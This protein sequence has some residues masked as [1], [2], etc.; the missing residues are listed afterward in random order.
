MVAVGVALT[1][2]AWAQPEIDLQAER[3]DRKVRINWSNSPEIADSL[4]GG[5]QVWRST[6]PDPDTFVLLR[7]FQRRYP[8]T[9]TYGSPVPGGRRF[10]DD[11]DSVVA[12][13]KVQINE[14]GDSAVTREYVG[15]RPFNGFPYF[16][17]TT[18]LSE[19][20]SQ[21]NDTLW[22]DQPQPTIEQVPGQERYFFLQN[23]DTLDV[24][25]IR[26]RRIDPRT[27]R[28]DTTRFFF[29]Y[30]GTVE[31][32]EPLR[33]YAIAATR[34]ANDN[35]DPEPVFPSTLAKQSL[36]Q[37]RAVPNPYISSA[38]WEEPGRRKI[39]FVN[40]T[41]E[42]TIRIYTAGAD[43]VREIAHPTP[44]APPDQGSVDWDLKNADGEVVESGI[45]IFQIE[46]PGGVA[47]F[48]GRLVIV[49]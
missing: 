33:H 46:T 16:Y 11:P 39:Q 22:V 47:D 9:W 23:G 34:L 35:G 1:S 36:N 20:L 15:T 32:E 2:P 17:A 4:F 42:A 3:S 7:R 18:W 13:R 29:I 27:N 6:S 24:N 14:E 5:Y 43:L 48:Q 41:Q 31:S 12:L 28:P 19:C 49:R 45:Y 10:F 25:R 21:L 8:V 40:L 26:C 44:G 38:N 30:T 37:V